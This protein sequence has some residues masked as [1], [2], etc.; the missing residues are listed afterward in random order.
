MPLHLTVFLPR[1]RFKWPI[2]M[3]GHHIQLLFIVYLQ[4]PY[5]RGAVAM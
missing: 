3:V 2:W 4:L 5:F 1:N